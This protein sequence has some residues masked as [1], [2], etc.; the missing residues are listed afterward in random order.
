MG[1]KP[2]EGFDNFAVGVG[3]KFQYAFFNN[4]GTANDESQFNYGAYPFARFKITEEVYI[5]GEYNFFSR[6]LGQNS[7]RINFNFPL[8]GA[9][10]VQGFDRWKFGFELLLLLPDNEI[11]NL[12]GATASDLY[13]LLEYN[14]AFLYNL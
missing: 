6:D 14:L 7:D 12:G 10:Y 1:I 5:K 2:F 9:G 13:T 3:T 11:S 8:I 4:F